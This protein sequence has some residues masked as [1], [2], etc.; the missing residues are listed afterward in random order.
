[1]L[2]R[3][4]GLPLA[5]ALLIAAFP[6][7]TRSASLNACSI[8]THADVAAVVGKGTV[9]PGK[10]QPQYAGDPTTTCQYDTEAGNVVVTLDPTN[11]NQFLS[12]Y[13]AGFAS[14]LKPVAGIGDE[15]LY[16]GEHGTLLVRKGQS[17]L[18][19]TLDTPDE[20]RGHAIIL[21]LAHRVVPRLH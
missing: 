4:V 14:S 18:M 9:T 6:S 3:Y 12:R 10:L 21:A 20:A 11:H 5:V 13:K 16:Y 17:V 8:V 1:M 7:Q 2:V 19:L 15:A